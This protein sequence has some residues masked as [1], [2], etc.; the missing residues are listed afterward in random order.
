MK[1]TKV[2]EIWL[3]PL[4]EQTK[5]LSSSS[6]RRRLFLIPVFNPATEM[7][8]LFLFFVS[9]FSFVDVTVA[10]LSFASNIFIHL[11]FNSRRR[12]TPCVM[13]LYPVFVCDYNYS[14]CPVVGTR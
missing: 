8:F 10:L 11:V 5:R 9:F 12:P 13:S 14:L 1:Q 3:V 2:D 6:R 7:K 4:E